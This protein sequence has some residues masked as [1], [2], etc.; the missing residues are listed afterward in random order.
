MNTVFAAVQPDSG[1]GAGGAVLLAFVL[2][3]LFRKK[4]P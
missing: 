4:K 3:F 2:Y 1:E